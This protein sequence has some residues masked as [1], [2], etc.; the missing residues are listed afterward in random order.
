MIDHKAIGKRLGN[1][2]CAKGYT[3]KT[4][5]EET[6]I[7]QSTLRRYICGIGLPRV[8]RWAIMASTL[9]VSLDYIL[10]L[11]DK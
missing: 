6:G 2:I 11:T 1:C 3:I 7:P 4:F 10:C 8:R 9:K 5:A